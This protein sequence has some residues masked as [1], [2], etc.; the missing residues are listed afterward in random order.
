MASNSS[1]PSN[2]GCASARHRH[3][4]GVNQVRPIELGA[5]PISELSAPNYSRY[6]GRVGALAV[7]LGV[8]AAVA[9]M[10]AVGKSAAMRSMAFWNPAPR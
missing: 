8:G 7:A 1:Q 5:R 6:V 3:T 4:G 9:A 2:R 10:P